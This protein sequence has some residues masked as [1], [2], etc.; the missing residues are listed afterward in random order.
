VAR[1]I[2]G[3]LL[4]FLGVHRQKRVRA[5]ECLASGFFLVNA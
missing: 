5:F 2:V 4:N 3:A 1:V